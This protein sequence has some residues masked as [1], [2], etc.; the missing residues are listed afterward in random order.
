VC[1]GGC[2]GMLLS[3]LVYKGL[4]QQPSESLQPL[5]QLQRDPQLPP[6]RHV[7]LNCPRCRGIRMMQRYF[8][9]EKK[10]LV[11]ECGQCGQ[12]WLHGGELQQ[13]LQEYGGKQQRLQQAEQ[14]SAVVQAYLEQ[15]QR[16]L[17]QLSPLQRLFPNLTGVNKDFDPRLERIRE[18]LRRPRPQ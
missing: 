17:E 14:R 3:G 2:G 7:K 8:S 5:L 15:Q 11:N 1:A 10:A 4:F 18:E 6:L 9:Q 12:V 13:A 16:K